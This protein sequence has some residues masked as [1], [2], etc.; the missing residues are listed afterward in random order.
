MP[1]G[2]PFCLTDYIE[3]VD[4]SGRILRED[5]RGFI[6]PQLSPTLERLNIESEHWV[7]L[8]SHFESRF[9]SFVGTAFK[10]KQVCQSLGYQRTPGIRGCECYFP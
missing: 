2:L 9:K 1:K 7:Y 4:M 6:D 5:K 8:I 10:L 3:L